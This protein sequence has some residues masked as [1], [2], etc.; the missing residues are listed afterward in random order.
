MSGQWEIVERRLGRAGGPKQR[1]ARQRQWDKQY[2]EDAWCVGYVLDGQFVPYEEALTRIYQASY[3]AY[4]DA[5]PEQVE[6]L[7]GLAKLLRNPHA[8]ATGG[9]DL[10]V[11]AIMDYL[12]R[13]AISLSGDQVVDI[14]SYDGV[15]SHAISVRL[16]PLQIPC[17]IEPRQTLEAFWQQRKCLAIWSE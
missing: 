6:A 5:H 9:V 14:G 4:L 17:V 16:S 8:Q 1:A 15:A 10:Q 2:G 13:R 3:D 7:T 12:R 11:P